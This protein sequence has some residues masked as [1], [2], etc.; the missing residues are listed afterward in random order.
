MKKINRDNI[1]TVLGLALLFAMMTFA[2]TNENQ[3]VSGVEINIENNEKQF[4]LHKEDINELVFGLQDSLLKTPVREINIGMLEDT[5]ETL[6]YV[7]NS[8]V[9]STLDGKLIINIE[10]NKAIARIHDKEKQFYLNQLG[11]AMPLSRYHS[12]MVP[13]IT[14]EINPENLKYTHQFLL[15][16]ANDPFYSSIITGID[17]NKHNGISIYTALGNHKVIWGS[18]DQ[19]DV[20]L[21]RLKVFYQS[22][23]TDK[24]EGLK[25]VNVMYN[26]QVVY[27]N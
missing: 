18:K 8:E 16:T 12:A 3:P 24:I 6:T 26:N 2:T 20:K 10:Q 23:G 13:F 4:F 19:T 21:K 9:F 5:L 15:T 22:L 14:G 25:T 7:R 17:F 1:F 27:T 11:E